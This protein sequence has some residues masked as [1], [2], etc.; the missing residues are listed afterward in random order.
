M[1]VTRRECV[2]LEGDTVFIIMRFLTGTHEIYNTDRCIKER[3]RVTRDDFPPRVY[4]L[5][6]EYLCHQ[7]QNTRTYFNIVTAEK[8]IDDKQVCSFTWVQTVD[9]DELLEWLKT[10]TLLEE[11]KLQQDPQK[12]RTRQ[13]KLTPEELRERKKQRSKEYYL[14][15]KEE[16]NEKRKE[17]YQEHKQEKKEYRKEYYQQ[18]KD[19]WYEK[20]I[21]KTK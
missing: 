3:R 6:T 17:Y 1:S 18:H 10:P 5:K 20:Y 7:K 16:L 19:E 2:G 4:F 14:K 21:K 12:K 13:S 15:H 9:E 11:K 8:Y